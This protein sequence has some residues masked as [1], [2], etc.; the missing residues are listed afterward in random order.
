MKTAPLTPLKAAEIPQLSSF[1]R[2]R[3]SLRERA[4]FS[5]VR[6]W[7]SEKVFFRRSLWR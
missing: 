7:K 3:T 6:P 2:E 1:N 5:R 4:D